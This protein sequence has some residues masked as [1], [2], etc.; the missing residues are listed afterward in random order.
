MSSPRIALSLLLL[1]GPAAGEELLF[2]D[3][4][5]TGNP[6]FWSALENAP[7]EAVGDSDGDRLDDCAER[8]TGVF[9][10]SDDTGTD[11]LLAD[12]DGDGIDDGDEVL[13]TLAGLDLP[14][15]GVHPLVRNVL[16]E[17][18]WF[19][20]NADPT[21]PSQPYPKSCEPHSHRPSELALVKVTTAFAGAGGLNP[22][23][24]AGI[25]AIHDYGQGAPFTGGNL[26]PDVD[27]VIAGGVGGNDFVAIKSEHFASE[28]QG[29][30]H[31]ALLPH[32]YNNNDSSSGQAELPG[33]DLIV[34]LFCFAVHPEESRYVG[35][36]ILH[37]L[38]HNF[39]LGHG[40]FESCNR[41]PN[42][43]SV[44][45]YNYQFPGVDTNCTPPGDGLL[46]YS[47]GTRIDLDE[48]DL[49]ETLGTCGTAPWDWDDDETLEAGVQ[50]DLNLD[51]DGNATNAGCGGIFTILRDHDDWSALDLA[52]FAG[53]GDGAE[54]RRPARVVDCDNVPPGR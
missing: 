11:P 34:S 37:E 1:A 31:Y 44:M 33:D 18:D 6:V 54:P 24:S 29:Y 46:D 20:D 4:F 43:N 45:N 5:E 9:V 7:C 17:Y 13:G 52:A 53:D 38:G 2:A 35:H 36:T 47:R 28:R 14:E 19:D 42:Y 39:D 50:Q 3:G 16:V 40:G 15:L 8:D 27:G 48:T 51:G 49:D 25:L 32:R 30:F 21:H 41:K 10:D 12:T 22:D 23:G 26:V